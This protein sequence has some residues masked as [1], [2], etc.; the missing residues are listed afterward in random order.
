MSEVE[1]NPQA[2]I[3]EPPGP[4]VGDQ[5]EAVIDDS[6][7]SVNWWSG[8]GS[9]ATKWSKTITGEFFSMKSKSN[10]ISRRE[11]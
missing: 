8:W 3:T 5:S 9:S 1:E 11:L 10:C 4:E 6:Q 2:P 7:E